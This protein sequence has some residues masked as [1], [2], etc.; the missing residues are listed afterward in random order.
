MPRTGY[1]RPDPAPAD[2]G[3]WKLAYTVAEAAA[4]A[5]VGTK[6]IY[7]AIRSGDLDHR[8][9]TAQKLLIP[10]AGLLAWIETLPLDRPE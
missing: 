5:G 6:T 4:A 9:L 1:T 7:A 2:P 10:R 8:W 3:A